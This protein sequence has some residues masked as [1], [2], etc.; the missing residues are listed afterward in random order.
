M[1]G[2]LDSC[3]FFGQKSWILAWGELDSCMFWELDSCMF[4]E[5]DS[6]M[7]GAGFLHVLGMQESSFFGQQP[8][9]ILEPQPR[10]RA[11]AL[12]SNGIFNAERRYSNPSSRSRADA[13]FAMVKIGFSRRG[14]VRFL[15][16]RKVLQSLTG[17]C[18][19]FV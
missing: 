2:E 13:R 7:G 1:M 10:V 18:P 15:G 12:Y 3:M 19:K 14:K 4:W 17:C 8:I 9:E 6:C 5:L 11:R 16:K